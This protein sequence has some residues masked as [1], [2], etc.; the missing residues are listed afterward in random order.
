MYI[1][2]L[3]EGI[4]NDL[5]ILV[6]PLFPLI[7]GYYGWLIAKKWGG[8]NSAFGRAISF[9]SLGFFAQF[10]GQMLYDFYQIYLRVEI[11]YPS[12]G[13]LFYFGSVLLYVLGAYQLAKVA[14]LKIT[15][16]SSKGIFLAVVIPLIALIGSYIILLQGYDADWSNKTVI[17]LDF[18]YPIGQA[19]YLSIALLV[20]LISKNILGGLMRRPIMLLLFALIA[21]FIADFVFSYQVSREVVTFYAGGTN[22]LMFAFAYF[23]MTIALLTMGNMFNKI[24]ES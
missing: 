4:Q 1:R 17:F 19:I 13:D 23:L 3:T 14:G 24:R 9:L 12:I 6:Y 11:P 21:Q 18:G 10:I 5:F 22:D 16:K 20:L 7:G 15:L 8:F 2:G